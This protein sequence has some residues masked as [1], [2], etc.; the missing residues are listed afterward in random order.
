MPDD[1]SPY[2]VYESAYDEITKATTWATDG[3]RL[4]E[5]RPDDGVVVCKATHLT[6]FT[7]TESFEE[8]ITPTIQNIIKKESDDEK[9]FDILPI[10][11]GIAGLLVIIIGTVSLRERR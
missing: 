2:C 11:I 9:Y 1:Y 5:V 7:A 3:V 6:R 10:M 8:V 4:H